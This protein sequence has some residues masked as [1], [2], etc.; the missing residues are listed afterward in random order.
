MAWNDLESGKQL[1]A[2]ESWGLHSQS[3]SSSFKTS[4]PNLFADRAASFILIRGLFLNAM[5]KS[6]ICS[7]PLPKT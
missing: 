5:L 1:E 4:M 3:K 7:V 6:G 2:F